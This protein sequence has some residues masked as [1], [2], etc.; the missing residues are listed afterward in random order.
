M[1][2]ERLNEQLSHFGSN[3]GG[4]VRTRFAGAQ[5][6][7]SLQEGWPPDMVDEMHFAVVNHIHGFGVQLWRNNAHL[8]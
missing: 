7:L 6:A 2:K 4:C 8:E 5:S 1:L 3:P